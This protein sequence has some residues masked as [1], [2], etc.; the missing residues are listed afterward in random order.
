M[1]ATSIPTMNSIVQYLDITP[2]QEYLV[3]RVKGR[4]VNRC[5]VH[6]LL[7]LSGLECVLDKGPNVC[8]FVLSIRAGPQRLHELLSLE[9]WG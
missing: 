6:L 5:G 1:K 9:W 2:N 3:D 4:F 8:V 7:C